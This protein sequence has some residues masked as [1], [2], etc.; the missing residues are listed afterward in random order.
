M[1][2]NPLAEFRG[3]L[4]MTALFVLGLIGGIWAVI[5]PFV[6]GWPLSNGSWTHSM[7]AIE[8]PGAALILVSGVAIMLTTGFAARA[9]A[10]ARALRAEE[11]A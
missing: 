9:A 7:W 10:C 1:N 8:L 11:P 4:G 6:T 2:T 5:A 3:F